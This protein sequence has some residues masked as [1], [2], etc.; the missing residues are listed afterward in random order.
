MNKKYFLLLLLFLPAILFAQASK[1]K[2]AD[3]YYENFAY[4][5]AIEEYK[6]LLEKEYNQAYNQQQLANSYYKLRDPENAVKYYA[7]VVEQPNVSP[8]V[9]FNYAQMLRG[10]REY[11]ASRRWL[12]KYQEAARN[13]KGVEQLLKS[14]DINVYKGLESFRVRPAGFN[15]Q[16]SDFGSFENNGT[17]YF[18][19]ARGTADTKTKIY[20]W[21]GEPF[22][23]IY[24]V[25]AGSNT[26]NPVSGDVNTVRHEGPVTLSADGNTMYFTRNN[27]LKRDGKKDDEGI[28]H[29]KIYKASLVNG[30][31]SNIEELP[32]SNN[33]YSVG[34]PS[35]SADGRTLYFVSEAPGGMGGSDIYKVSL[36]N[37]IFGTPE[38]LGAPVNTP[39][40]EVFPFIAENGNFYFSSDGH[41]GYGL[42]DVFVV[43]T[44][45]PGNVQNLGEP[46]NSSMD[47]FSFSVS[48]AENT[49]GFISSNRTGGQGNDDIYELNILA[50]LVLKGKVTDS[51]NDKPIANATLRLLDQSNQQLAVLETDSVGNYQVEI[52]RDKTYPLESKHIKYNT[53]ME[54]INTSSMDEKTELVHNIELSPINDVEYLAEINKIYFDFDKAN[55]RPDAATEL[56]K[57]VNLMKNEYPELVIEI[58][59][60]TDRRGSAA[61]NRR[62]AERR[63]QATRDY[64]VKNGIAAERIVTYKGYGEEQP[65]VDCTTCNEEQHQL[66]RRSIFK[67]VK[68]E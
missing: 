10:V 39:G 44:E 38:N 48:G 56:D 47:D 8:E 68:M 19:S 20:D 9:Y 43:T 50:P 54:E 28:N 63:A 5:K 53:K 27:Y 37:G 15:S 6:D 18:T 60:H 12:E 21:T 13:P 23:D 1:Q 17:I 32:F 14:G 65:E 51:I 31:W 11:E 66:N 30:S 55:I 16:F 59:S 2:K 62:L 61:Y 46:V 40:N 58:G 33:E 45:A 3:R 52:A 7:M 42:L 64:L 34:H 22:L 29:L 67:V 25:T 41:K 57:L 24:K 26:V 36:E 49:K 35:L 4:T